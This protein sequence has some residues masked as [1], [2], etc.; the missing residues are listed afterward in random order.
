MTNEA[1]C[2]T[3]DRRITEN[4]L[5]H[6][7]VGARLTAVNYAAGFRIEF[8]RASRVFAEGVPLVARL[9][10]RSD[11]QIGSALEWA[12]LFSSAPWKTI[13][14]EV[15][16]PM[17]AYALAWLGGSAITGLDVKSGGNLILQTEYGRELWVSGSD[18]TFDESW[19]VDVPRDVPNHEFWSV[20]C[21]DT[22]ELWCRYPK[23]L[24]VD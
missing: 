15:H 3:S 10:L 1:G 9:T 4:V 7:L 12:Q 11:W 23:G 22:G 18:A 17:R 6:L 8:A 2:T 21:S 19:I 20:V 24:A 5:R 13:V 14:G 16:D